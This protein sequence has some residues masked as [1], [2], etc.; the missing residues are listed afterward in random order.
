MNSKRLIAGC[1]DF[2]IATIIQTVLMFV[3]IMRPFLL[4][5][6][7]SDKVIL[8]NFVITFISI[9]YMVIRDIMGERSV[10]KRIMNLK[11][12]YKNKN[13]HVKLISRLC[14][15]IS[16]FLGPVEI[17]FFLIKGYRLGD[18]IAKTDI[19]ISQNLNHRYPE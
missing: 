12:I 3:F 10:G 17:L 5:T 19:V 13:D 18:F 8:L 1:I 4:D 11:I 9:L 7:K 16:W 14:R 6:I 2:L 15:N